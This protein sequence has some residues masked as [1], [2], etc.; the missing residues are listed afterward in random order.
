MAQFFTFNTSS[1]LDEYCYNVICD[2]SRS[3]SFCHKPVR[4]K[5]DSCCS[6]SAS[7][8]PNRLDSNYPID[9]NPPVRFTGFNKSSSPGIN[10]DSKVEY[11]LES[12]PDDL[13]LL[14]GADY[15]SDGAIVMFKENGFLLK[16]NDLD[17]QRVY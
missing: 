16:L 17:Q 11:Y 3:S 15:A 5:I 10:S 13:V 1:I 4:I 6:K 7:G 14:C 12:M 2:D 9:K 8:V